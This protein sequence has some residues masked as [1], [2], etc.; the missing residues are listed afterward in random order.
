MA[1]PWVSHFDDYHVE[2]GKPLTRQRTDGSI[3]VRT[4]FWAL[5]E[6]DVE[7]CRKGGPHV[8]FDA[9]Y[10]A[11]E[12][13][14][15]SP[16]LKMYVRGRD[17]TIEQWPRATRATRAIWLLQDERG[18]IRRCGRGSIQRLLP[19]TPERIEWSQATPWSAV[20]REAREDNDHFQGV[21][22]A[23]RQKRVP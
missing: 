5:N 1:A 19:T 18:V 9:T 10:S 13:R 12:L 4:F 16:Y 6:N 20:R 3:R 14:D 15:N 7:A 22:A 11:S 2:T 23:L 8:C 17:G 21:C